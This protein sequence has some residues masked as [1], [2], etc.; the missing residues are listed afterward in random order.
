MNG[1]R[2]FYS[3]TRRRFFTRFLITSGIRQTSR[4]RYN[5]EDT[6]REWPEWNFRLILLNVAHC[7]VRGSV[8]LVCPLAPPRGQLL[9]SAISS[10]LRSNLLLRFPFVCT[11]HDVCA[12]NTTSL[13]AASSSGAAA[14]A[15]SA[16]R[17]DSWSLTAEVV[18]QL[19]Q[20][21]HVVP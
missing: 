20:S 4:T 14:T 2:G 12:S 7:D 16:C 9:R 15:P 5:E 10:C 3:T 8:G 17:K 13:A 19:G 1:Y 18:D 21:R 6:Q 11:I